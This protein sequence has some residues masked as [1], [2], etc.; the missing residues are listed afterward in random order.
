VGIQTGHTKLSLE[1]MIWPDTL[2]CMARKIKG[3]T[4]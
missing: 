4:D 1:G 3:I 2:C